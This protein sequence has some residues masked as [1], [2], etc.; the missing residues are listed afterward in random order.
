MV[1]PSSRGVL[2]GLSWGSCSVFAPTD[3]QQLWVSSPSFGFAG[4]W[5]EVRR[6]RSEGE[7]GRETFPKVRKKEN[8]PQFRMPIFINGVLLQRNERKIINSFAGDKRLKVSCSPTSAL[9]GP[10]AFPLLLMG[11]CQPQLHPGGR[12][13][14]H[15]PNGGTWRGWAERSALNS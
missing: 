2:G 6:D 8:K 15:G 1:L 7:K 3:P 14:I 5:M 10:E 4:T 13:S 9:L 11:G 12:P